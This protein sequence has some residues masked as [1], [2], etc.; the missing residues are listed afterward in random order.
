MG[1]FSFSDEASQFDEPTTTIDDAMRFLK[2]IENKHRKFGIDPS[3]AEAA[4]A[5]LRER[6]TDSAISLIQKEIGRIQES[7]AL[8][9]QEGSIDW[10]DDDLDE[11]QMILDF[12]VNMPQ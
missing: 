2:R 4:I 9:G 8:S 12:L 7:V 10:T 3:E 1:L 11:A 6:Y 5:D